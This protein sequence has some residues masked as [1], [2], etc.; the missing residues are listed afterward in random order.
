RTLLTLSVHQ[1]NAGY[2]DSA[3]VHRWD[4]QTGKLLGA[5]H[6]KDTYAW[7]SAL[8]PDGRTAA[9]RLFP[10]LLLTD[11][12]SDEDIWSRADGTLENW[13]G[14]PVFSPDGGFL[15]VWSRD[16]YVGMWEMATQSV[17]SRLC[18]RRDGNIQLARWPAHHKDSKKEP[19]IPVNQAE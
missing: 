8:G 4:T 13:S 2:T 18:L 16:G 6:R 5:V 1:E 11:L 10:G 17:I 7:G 15:F 12:E 19:E 14:Y 3:M 9:I